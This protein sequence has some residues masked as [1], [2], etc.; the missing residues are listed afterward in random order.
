M[1][2]FGAA[3][4]RGMAIVRTVEELL[5]VAELAARRRCSKNHI[6]DLIAAGEPQAVHQG[7]GRAKT[8]V[9]ASAAAAFIAKRTRRAA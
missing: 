9:S 6:Y 5:P 1:V 3:T 2:W 8:R 4:L 7:T